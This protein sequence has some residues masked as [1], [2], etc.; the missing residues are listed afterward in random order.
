VEESGIVVMSYKKDVKFDADAERNR[1][2]GSR[3]YVL[4]MTCHPCL[5]GAWFSA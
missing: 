4:V 1:V 3:R 2:A 5:L